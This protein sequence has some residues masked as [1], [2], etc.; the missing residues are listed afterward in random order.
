M[1]SL[2]T[3]ICGLKLR[4]PTILASGI[5]DLTGSSMKR[6]V[7]K[8]GAGAVVTK[9]IS[10]GPRE[11]HRNPSVIVV[12]DGLLN[13][14]GLSNPGYKEF[15]SEIVKAKTA[16]APVIGSVFGKTPDEFAEVAGAL[17]SYGVDAIEINL[18][19]PNVKGAQYSQDP[20]LSG[21]V[22]RAVKTV[23][24]KPVIAKLTSEVPSI[25]K[26]ASACVDA[27]CD[28]V[29]AINTIRAMKIDIEAKA[30]ILANVIGGLS[31]TAIK[32]IAVRCVYEIAGELS[33]PVIGCG[34]I[35]TGRDAVEFLM[36]GASAIQIGTAVHS[37]GIGVFHKVA[38]EIEAFMEKE[39]YRNIEELVGAAL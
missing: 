2:S 32:P 17:T 25:V 6:V 11:G 30:P 28:G 15:H 33:V 10:V 24:D 27:G 36:A 35:T 7:E 14:I 8:G 18:S 29:T 34:G 38:R 5:L 19:C 31:G 12:E 20:K 23:V 16:G 1:P 21:E 3:E 26:I 37:R 13:A 22:V 39:G 9:S 4:N